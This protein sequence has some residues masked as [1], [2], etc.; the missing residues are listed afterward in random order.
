MFLSWHN[1]LVQIFKKFGSGAKHTDFGVEVE[2]VEPE[3]KPEVIYL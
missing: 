1:L 2:S 3:K